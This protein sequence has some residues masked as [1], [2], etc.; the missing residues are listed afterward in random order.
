MLIAVTLCSCGD[1]GEGRGLA[2]GVSGDAFQRTDKGLVPA[3]S[4]SFWLVPQGNLYGAVEVKTDEQGQFR[5]R[6][7]PGTYRVQLVRVRPSNATQRPMYRVM[8]IAVEE[9]QFTHFR[10]VLPDPL[11]R[12]KDAPIILLL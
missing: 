2:G 12:L 1:F 9:G 5:A 6:L 8:M 7:E 4:T 11:E 10:L 3:A